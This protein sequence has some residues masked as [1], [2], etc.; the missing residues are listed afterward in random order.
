MQNQLKILWQTDI[1]QSA[2]NL[3]DNKVI[4]DFGFDANYIFELLIMRI[5][6]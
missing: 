4:I 1:L 2:V 3:N 6:G 5:Y